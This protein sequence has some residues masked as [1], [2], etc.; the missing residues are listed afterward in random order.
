M[1]MCRFP[2]HIR[3]TCKN[4]RFKEELRRITHIP[5]VWIYRIEYNAI[6]KVVSFAQISENMY[7]FYDY[8]MKMECGRFVPMLF[9]IHV[10]CSTTDNFELTNRAE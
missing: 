2:F 10:E 4:E 3:F 1:L 6:A 7:M 8:F 9:N 5:C